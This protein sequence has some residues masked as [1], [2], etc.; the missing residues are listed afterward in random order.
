ME[1]LNKE[2]QASRTT[3]ESTTLPESPVSGGDYTNL[4]RTPTQQQSLAKRSQ[5][6]LHFNLAHRQRH[7]C[8]FYRPEQEVLQEQV[9]EEELGLEL[10]GQT[11][12]SPLLQEA[13]PGTDGH[14]TP[15]KS[16]CIHDEH[17]PPTDCSDSC[18]QKDSVLDAT[19]P[20]VIIQESCLSSTPLTSA[21][22]SFSEARAGQFN[23]Q[24]QI[25]PC[26]IH[27]T[28]CDCSSNDEV[29]WVHRN[30]A[31]PPSCDVPEPQCACQ[32]ESDSEADVLQV[33]IPKFRSTTSDSP[34][35]LSS[36]S[37]LRQRRRQPRQ[38]RKKSSPLYE[39]PKL[40]IK[41]AR[42]MIAE[43]CTIA[44]VV[45]RILFTMSLLATVLAY[46]FIL[47]VVPSNNKIMTENVTLI[48]Y[49]NASHYRW[50]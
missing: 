27:E 21:I 48:N 6:R 30:D 44:K 49:V 2:S 41:R 29:V 17:C 13:R 32:S 45:D 40:A 24:Y 38:R 3:N 39:N 37:P 26:M 18:Q 22:D 23:K 11:V 9:V 15:Y 50:N 36:S 5:N 28:F 8:N 34:M 35:S 20:T 25:T 31:I 14:Y 7:G 12:D 46:V 19:V 33:L 4:E 1:R 42:I 10:L 43:W 47:I 16:V